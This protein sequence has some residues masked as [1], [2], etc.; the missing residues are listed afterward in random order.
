MLALLFSIAKTFLRM[1]SFF[2]QLLLLVLVIFLQSLL[3]AGNVVTQ[4]PIHVPQLLTCL[5]NFLPSLKE[6]APQGC[7]FVYLFIPCLLLFLVIFAG[8]LLD[9]SIISFQ[10]F[11]IVFLL[12]IGPPS[13]IKTDDELA[14]CLLHLPKYRTKLCSLWLSF[15]F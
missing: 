11:L 13:I 14:I 10:I 7:P 2:R 6:S 15:R 4:T 5:I 12:W 9:L 3:T 8:Q 1:R